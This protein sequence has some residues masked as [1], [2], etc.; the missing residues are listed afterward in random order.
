MFFVLILRWFMHRRLLTEFRDG[1][2]SATVMFSSAAPRYQPR[3][4]WDYNELY[5]V[6][7]FLLP[8]ASPNGVVYLLLVW[9]VVWGLFDA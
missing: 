3:N 6:I 1:N 8:K 2:A 7:V 4:N 5:P 9:K